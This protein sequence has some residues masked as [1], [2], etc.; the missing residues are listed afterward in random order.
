ML[1]NERSK[2][3]IACRAATINHGRRFAS[4]GRSDPSI[5]AKTPRKN[6]TMKLKKIEKKDGKK[7]IKVKTNVKAGASARGGVAVCG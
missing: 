2:E 1:E 3:V 4:E 5:R 6:R 7:D